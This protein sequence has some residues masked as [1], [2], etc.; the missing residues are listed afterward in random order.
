[1]SVIE[2]FMKYGYLLLNLLFL[3]LGIDFD[4]ETVAFLN[5]QWLKVSAGFYA[6]PLV[7]SGPL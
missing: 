3:P 7:W 2:L 4:S 5:K 1:M 6:L